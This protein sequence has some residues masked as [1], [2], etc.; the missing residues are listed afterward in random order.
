M[1]TGAAVTMARPFQNFDDG[2]DIQV[3][4]KYVRLLRSRTRDA[5]RSLFDGEGY[6]DVKPRVI[7]R[8]TNSEQALNITCVANIC[9]RGGEELV[10]FRLCNGNFFNF[11]EWSLDK[12]R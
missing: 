8:F 3:P 12:S 5:E 2:A 4:P 10:K 6:S 9:S 11:R 7:E 1:L